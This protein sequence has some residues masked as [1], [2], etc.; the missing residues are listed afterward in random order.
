[1]TNRSEPMQR[2][3]QAL[4]EH[5]LDCEIRVIPEGTRTSREAAD[6]IGCKIAE[7]AKSI[8]L[9]SGDDPVLVIASGKNRVD[10]GKVA[11]KFGD[12]VEMMD[13]DSVKKI[14]GFPV[15]GVPPIGH[16]TKMEILIDE[17]LLDFDI[18]WAAA[19]TI[20]SVFSL[21]PQDLVMITSGKV[22]DVKES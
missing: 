14:T 20:K 6:A 12:K 2:V 4:E 3:K 1:M 13:A 19:G 9:F 5:G 22:C 16:D 11:N 18:V 10:L 17:D 21:T 8:A 7:I 15:G